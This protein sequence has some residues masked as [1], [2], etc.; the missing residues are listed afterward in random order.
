MNDPY[1][2]YI[3]KICTNCINKECNKQF[4]MT[5]RNNMKTIKCINYIKPDNLQGY[6]E[7]L[8][9]EAKQLRSLMGFWQEY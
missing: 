2:T 6:K 1:L 3:D 7:P 5:E 9:R 4:V 8:E